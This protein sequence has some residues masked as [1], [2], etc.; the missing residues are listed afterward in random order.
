MA[1][2]NRFLSFLTDPVPEYAFEVSE[3]GIAWA[4]PSSPT[5]LFEPLEPGTITVSP[6]A[7]NV[8]KADALADRVRKITGGASMKRRGAVVI[9]PDYSARVAVLEFDSFPSDP[10]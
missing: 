5:P 7:D 1:L 6:L 8:H 10:K 4:R 3:A 2:G 9:L